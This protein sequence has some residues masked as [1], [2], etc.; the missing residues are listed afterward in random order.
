M[1]EKNLKGV[2]EE[3]VKL[4]KQIEEVEKNVKSKKKVET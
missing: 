2:Q 3:R 4:G 1:E